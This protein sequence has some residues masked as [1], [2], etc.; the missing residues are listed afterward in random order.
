[1][2]QITMKPIK[3]KAGPVGTGMCRMAGLYRKVPNGPGKYG[4]KGLI[5]TLLLAL[6]LAVCTAPSR[7]EAMELPGRTATQCIKI[8]LHLLTSRQQQV[9]LIETVNLPKILNLSPGI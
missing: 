9:T 6:V 3:D 2:M 5:G 8:F 7:A 4:R 1:M